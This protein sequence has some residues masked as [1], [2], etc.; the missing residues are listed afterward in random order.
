LILFGLN[1]FTLTWGYIH[2]DYCD[3]HIDSDAPDF[4][5]DRPLVKG[6]I[7]RKAALIAIWLCILINL[8]VPILLIRNALLSG[9]LVVAIIGTA[10]YNELSKKITG[11]D[12]FYAGSAAVLV[13]FGALYVSEERTLSAVGAFVWVIVV[14][15]LLDHLFYN[16]VEGGMKDVVNDQKFGARTFA[17][18]SIEVSDG[19]MSISA[20]YKG[21]MLIVKLGAIVLV[22]VPLFAMDIERSIGQLVALGIIAAASLYHSYRLLTTENY[23]RRYIGIHTLKQEMACKALVPVMLLHHAGVMWMLLLLFVPMLWFGFFNKLLHG[24]GFEFP[25]IY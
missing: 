24:K 13:L 1:V 12:F 10:L 8:S 20:L 5:H 7:S 14:I 23:D 17:C 3:R 21:S 2:N 19:K 18:R 16:I 11:A 4:L 9:I 22:F 15:Q 25:E 6:S